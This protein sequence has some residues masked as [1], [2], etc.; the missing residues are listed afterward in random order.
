MH[1]VT[2]MNVETEKDLNYKATRLKASNLSYKIEFAI[3]LA[4]NKLMMM[5]Y[6]DHAQSM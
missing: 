4:R 3:L 5:S 1:F 2:H 6:A